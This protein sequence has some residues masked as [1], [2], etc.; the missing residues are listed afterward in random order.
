L[1][2]IN[3]PVPMSRRASLLGVMLSSASTSS[4]AMM[5]ALESARK[6]M[7]GAVGRLVVIFNVR[8]S[9]TSILSTVAH[10]VER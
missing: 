7:K 4:L 8:L 6:W 5:K 3:G 1:S 9:T 10:W 2:T